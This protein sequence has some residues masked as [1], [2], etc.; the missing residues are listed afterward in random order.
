[1]KFGSKA[2]NPDAYYAL[3]R[4]LVNCLFGKFCVFVPKSNWVI[5]GIS[6]NSYT[7]GLPRRG[8]AEVVGAYFLVIINIIYIYIIIAA[9]QL[10]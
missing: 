1:M 2:H 4:H 7:P 6:A 10:K 9:E 8:A 3:Q 5:M